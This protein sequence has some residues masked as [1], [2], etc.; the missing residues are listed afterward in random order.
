TPAVVRFQVKPDEPGIRFYRVRAFMKSE[1]D[2]IFSQR[3]RTREATLANNV[4]IAMVDRGGGPY[5]I[6][7]VSGRPNWEFK[8]LRRSVEEDDEIQLV[9]LVRIAKREPKFD[10]R[11][12]QGE[13]TNPLFRGFG[14]QEDEQAEQYDQPVLLRLG[15]EDQEEL[16]DGFP[17]TADL[18][19]KYH[20]VVLDDVEVSYF[21]QDQ[22]LLL[23]QFVSHRGGGLVMLGGQESFA[24]GG[25]SRTP[26]GELLP[27]YLGKRRDVPPDRTYRLKLT[28]DGMHPPWSFFRVRSTTE[29]EQAR[30]LKMP[31]FQTVNRVDGV[32]PGAVV[33]A[34]AES[35]R[36]ES[37]P[38]FTAQRFGK[39]RSAAMLVGDLWR[40]GMRREKATNEDLGMIWRQTMRWIV[41]DVPR[42]VD[43]RA[44]TDP[45]DPDQ[46]QKIEIE[47]RDSEFKPLD[48]AQAKIEIKTPAGTVVQ[49]DAE[50]S[51]SKAGAYVATFVPREPGSYHA[52]VDV[53]APDGSETGQRDIGWVS[54]PETVEFRRLRPNHELMRQIADATGGD[55]LALDDLDRFVATLPNRKI[56]VTEPWLF[57]WW[58]RK[59]VKLF[60]FLAIV[61]FLSREWAARRLNGLP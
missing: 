25:Y 13:S 15:T 19:Y 58:E 3:S 50:P 51:E 47:V 38:A 5:R 33:L 14:N 16:R 39:G 36:G 26:L 4:R 28:R 31:S 46:T 54:E 60:A 57:S 23:Q 30:L 12:R 17:K 40:W 9:G 48:N 35:T 34:I 44:T 21:T 6:L 24:K 2:R 59:W 41:A 52:H 49:L 45:T 10:F 37:L 55:L 32:K 7:Y 29:E 11:S 18:L 53:T 42:R 43:A 22:M 1:G 20:A 27:V 8:F 56:P 61:G